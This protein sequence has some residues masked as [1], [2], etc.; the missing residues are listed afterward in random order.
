MN[1]HTTHA[2][3]AT[4]LLAVSLNTLRADDPPPAELAPKPP[5]WDV[6]GNAGFSMTSGNSDT[7]LATAGILASRKWET[8]NLDLGLN[9][10]YG[11][12]E[13]ERNVQTLR[14]FGQYDHDITERTF[15]YGRAE[16]LHDGIADIEYR[17]T[18]SPGAGYYFIKKDRMFLRGEVGPSWIYER[19]GNDTRDYFAVRFAERFEYKISDRARI[20][21]GIEFLPQVDRFENYLVNFEAGVESAL[22]EK[23]SLNFVFISNYVSEP[24]PDRKHNDIRFIAGLKYK[25]L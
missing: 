25:F 15:W 21:Q 23:L 20:Y 14:G 5:P 1:T 24:A 3:L 17:L 6:T 18:L 22:T 16:L 4:T 8:S 13:N 19:S 7:L 11:E 9:G 10:A 12:T 2:L